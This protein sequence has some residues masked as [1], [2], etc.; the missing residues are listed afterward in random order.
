MSRLRLSDLSEE[1]L[2]VIR[3]TEYEDILETASSDKGSQRSKRV[4]PSNQGGIMQFISPLI[5]KGVINAEIVPES[6]F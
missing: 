2:E 1:A 3:G 5:D 6:V 4:K